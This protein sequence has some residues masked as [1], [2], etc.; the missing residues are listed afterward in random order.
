MRRWAVASVTLVGAIALGGCD[1]PTRPERGSPVDAAT[2]DASVGSD[3]EVTVRVGFEFATADGGTIVL[4]APTLTRIDQVTVNGSP[5]AITVDGSEVEVALDGR[6]AEVGFQLHGAVERFEDVAVV[7]LPV[8][9]DVPGSRG[10]DPLVP[11]TGRVHLPGTPVGNPRWH[12][13]NPVTPPTA[14]GDAIILDGSVAPEREATIVVM[15]PSE[16]L[17][18]APV[19]PGGARSDYVEERQ[20]VLDDDDADA[21]ADRRAEERRVDL[22]AR[23]YWALVAIEIAAPLAITGARLGRSARKRLAAREGVPEYL[24]EPPSEDPP[25]VVALIANG[26]HDIGPEAV[27]ATV[28]DLAHRGAL[29]LDAGGDDSYVIHV[30]RDDAPPKAGPTG[31]VVLG[32]L[33]AKAKR[34]RELHGPPLGLGDG[35]WVRAFRRATLQQAKAAGL[36]QRRIPSG[37]FIVSVVALFVTT[38]P[39]FARS[40]AAGFGGFL[41]SAVLAALPFVGGYVL[42]PKGERARAEWDAF[43]RWVRDNSEIASAPPAAVT[44]WGPFL[45]YGAAVGGAEAAVRGLRP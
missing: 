33:R 4:Q 8:W 43:A 28:L 11:V 26:G 7:T 35:P 39:L 9:T 31:E 5:R 42:S 21:V 25:A 37:V 38:F 40:A 12:G 27:G 20:A 30:E 10:V 16:S 22:V 24:H 29:R 2:F 17:P 18:A 34:G 41:V 36:L 6:Q 44:V 1:A 19:L 23:G 32:A 45:S 15:V 13:S 3:G 14:D